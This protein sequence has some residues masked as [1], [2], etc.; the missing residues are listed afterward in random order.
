MRKR[1]A[2]EIYK[3][4]RPQLTE[5]QHMIVL[6]L[7]KQGADCHSSIPHEHLAETLARCALAL[8]DGAGGAIG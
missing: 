1:L 4:H 3:A 2:H 8:R 7:D 5:G 6:I